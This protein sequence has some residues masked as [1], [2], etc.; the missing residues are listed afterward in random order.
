MALHK[1]VTLYNNDVVSYHRITHVVIGDSGLDGRVKIESFE[2]HNQ[3]VFQQESFYFKWYPV[4]WSG[5]TNYIGDAYEALKLHP[6]FSG[7]TDV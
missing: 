2:D 5:N 4:V 7:A 1:P 6:D 3:R